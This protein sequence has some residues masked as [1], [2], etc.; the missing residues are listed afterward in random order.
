MKKPLQLLLICLLLASCSTVKLIK[1][2]K[3]GE[4]EQP[5]FKAEV[6]FE[7]RMGL[8]VV[9]V[10][11][12][13]KDYD[14]MVDTG[15]P[16]VIS[17]ELAAELNLKPK[18]YQK[19]GDSQ[20]RSEQ[21]G[22]V[23]MPEMLIG[24]IHFIETAAAVADLKQS[25]EIA[26]LGVDGFIGANLMKEAVWEF[27]YQ[28][29]VLSLADSISVFTIP[30]NAM[31]IP[32]FPAA[33][34]TP[35]VDISYDGVV[36]QRVTF[37]TGS[38]G[39]FN[40]SS[41]IREKLQENGKGIKP[42]ISCGASSSGL[43]G[44][45]NEDTSYTFTID[46]TKLGAMSIPGQAVSFA[47]SRSRTIGTKFFQHYRVIIDWSAKE[48]T[49]IPTDDFVNNT[50]ESFGFTP[51]YDGSK[52]IVKML[53]LGSAAEKSGIR[54]GD[55]I[56]E[57]NGENYRVM[58]DLKWCEMLYDEATFRTNEEITLLLRQGATE[59]TVKLTRVNLLQQ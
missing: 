17:K 37:D 15:A 40:S 14:F 12:N 9:K 11:I 32:F 26:C 8:V 41:H 33:S 24:E 2:L 21:L 56:L 18:V 57:I 13:G 38:N 55:E 45:G 31:K 27:D 3:K 49:M 43:Y 47:G 29:H 19:T 7:M 51:M 16:N 34:S 52:L 39:Y 59:R 53:V 23:E 42:V 22:F 6:P 36:D 1:M 4:V 46:E 50:M 58:S 30:D 48:I 44:V 35:L 5:S 20:G 25:R 54:L 10:N 28:R